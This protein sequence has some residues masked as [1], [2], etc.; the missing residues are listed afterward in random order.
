MSPVKEK[1]MTDIIIVQS[2]FFTGGIVAR[3]PSASGAAELEKAV[4]SAIAAN[5]D[6]KDVVQFRKPGD[7]AAV[8]AQIRQ[9]RAR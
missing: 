5:C 3:V 1:N 8:S 7:D 9:I 4:R 6:P 2:P